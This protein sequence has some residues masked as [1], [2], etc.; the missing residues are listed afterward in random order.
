MSGI[1]ENPMMTLAF[2]GP[3]LDE[4]VVRIPIPQTIELMN[5]RTAVGAASDQSVIS[6]LY[7]E[8][9]E[10]TILIAQ[11]TIA[12]GDGISSDDTWALSDSNEGRDIATVRAGEYLEIAF[13]YGG[14]VGQQ[15]DTFCVT[16]EYRGTWR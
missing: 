15:A 1:D 7:R 13:G 16:I 5:F 8:S 6:A 3:L 11:S 2:Y 10:G 12:A 4:S 9:D 14:A